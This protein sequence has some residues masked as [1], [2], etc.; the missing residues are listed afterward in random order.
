MADERVV[1]AVRGENVE[2]PAPHEHIVAVKLSDDSVL[3][4]GEV[5]ARL[6]ESGDHLAT[7]FGHMIHAVPCAHCGETILFATGKSSSTSKGEQDG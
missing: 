1:V 4:A 7:P 5:I 6:Q 3:T 2:T